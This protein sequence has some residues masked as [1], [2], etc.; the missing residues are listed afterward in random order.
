MNSFFMPGLSLTA[1]LRL[2]AALTF[3]T[4]VTVQHL[5]SAINLHSSLETQIH[6]SC[7][8]EGPYQFKKGC[9]MRTAKP[10]LMSYPVM[11][12]EKPEV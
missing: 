6:R 8:R 3:A 7:S 4:L 10:R 5:S 1:E 9:A 12:G 2:A 11:I